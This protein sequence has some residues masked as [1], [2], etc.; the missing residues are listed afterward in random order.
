MIDA[1]R[2]STL[3]N[4]NDSVGEHLSSTA[5]RTSILLYIVQLHGNRAATAKT[6]ELNV[7]INGPCHYNFRQ[8]VTRLFE[9][10]L[11]DYNATTAYSQP[12]DINQHVAPHLFPPSSTI[13]SLLTSP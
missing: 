3:T 8:G 1:K 6:S 4:W 5:P 10:Y 7:L 2:C 9:D 12:I 13:Q 11:A